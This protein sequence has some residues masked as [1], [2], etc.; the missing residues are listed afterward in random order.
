MKKVLALLAITTSFA[1][2]AA[3][4]AKH[5]GKAAH[6]GAHAAVAPAPQQ[7]APAVETAP[8]VPAAH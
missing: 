1:A 5:A 3:P 4:V 2:V 8:Q 6:K 7:A